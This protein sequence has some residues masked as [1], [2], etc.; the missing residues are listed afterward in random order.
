MTL[1]ERLAE[2]FARAKDHQGGGYNEFWIE[3][4]YLAGFEKGV[5]EAARKFEGHNQE[6]K[7]Y[8]DE[9]TLTYRVM[10]IIAE[11]IR[12]TGTEESK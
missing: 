5:A 1:K 11:H 2:E 3:L 12:L 10:D 8:F 6:F 4:G 9:T 7:T